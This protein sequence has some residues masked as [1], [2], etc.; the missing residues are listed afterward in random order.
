[1][2]ADCSCSLKV[3]FFKS[4]SLLVLRSDIIKDKV[5]G[6]TAATSSGMGNIRYPES[7]ERTFWSVLFIVFRW[8]FFFFVRIDQES[9]VARL[10]DSLCPSGIV[11]ALDKDSLVICEAGSNGHSAVDPGVDGPATSSS[12]FSRRA[13]RSLPKNSCHE[14]VVSSSIV[15]L[16]N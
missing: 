16:G 13:F 3:S 9:S 5:L 10:A 6:L 4:I 15:T 11:L 7:T 8:F 1:M 12:G 14:V 2:P